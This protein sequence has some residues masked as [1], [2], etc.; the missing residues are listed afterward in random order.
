MNNHALSYRTISG[1]PACPKIMNR[2]RGRLDFVGLA[3]VGTAACTVVHHFAGYGGR[4]REGRGRMLPVGG[5]KCTHW[6]QHRHAE[7]DL[8][9]ELSRNCVGLQS[10]K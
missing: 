9:F 10:V 6:L 4:R 8:E 3:V 1:Y 5:A 7:F 2:P